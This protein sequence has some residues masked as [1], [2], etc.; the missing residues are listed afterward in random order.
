MWRIRR[1][2]GINLLVHFWHPINATVIPHN[3]RLSTAPSS[4][5]SWSSL[6]PRFFSNL[7]ELSGNNWE[8]EQFK[9]LVYNSTENRFMISGDYVTIARWGEQ[10]QLPILWGGCVCVYI[11]SCSLY[12]RA[13]HRIASQ[14]SSA[15][16]RSHSNDGNNRAQKAA[17]SGPNGIVAA[18][19]S[20]SA[21]LLKHKHSYTFTC[22]RLP[23]ITG[24]SKQQQ[25]G[26]AS[27]ER[28]T[29]NEYCKNYDAFAWFIWKRRDIGFKY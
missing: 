7:I 28:E 13:P 24:V 12:F 27:M 23:V 25:Q 26:C 14:R 22:W 2:S 20:L 9:L 17:Q 15:F 11:G 5:S 1:D 16:G 10:Q 8:R 18:N 6:G 19:R 21:V 4:S 29:K 3:H